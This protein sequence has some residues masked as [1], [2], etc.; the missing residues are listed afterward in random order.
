VAHRAISVK[1]KPVLDAEFTE[2]FVAVIAFFSISGQ[3]YK[4]V[5]E[6][7]GTYCSRSNK[8]GSL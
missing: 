7:E 6:S 4:W 2:Q 1:Y 8:E 3:F 5:R